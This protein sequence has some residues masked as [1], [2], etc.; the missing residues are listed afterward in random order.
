MCKQ[1]KENLL[2]TLMS[3][4]GSIID[5]LDKHSKSIKKLEQRINQLSAMNSDVK[6][7]EDVKFTIESASLQ[8]C[9]CYDAANGEYFKFL[10]SEHPGAYIVAI[11][12]E[13]CRKGKMLMCHAFLVHEQSGVE[14]LYVAD[15]TL[16]A[17]YS[18]NSRGFCNMIGKY[19][20]FHLRETYKEAKL[21]VGDVNQINDYIKK[22]GYT[23]EFNAEMLYP[24]FS[25]LVSAKLIRPLFKREKIVL[26]NKNK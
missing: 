22:V 17:P 24:P 20:S 7:R 25:H 21:T 3:N 16:S 8:T 26:A 18:N 1:L 9:S 13:P 12:K 19:A 15:E 2:Q 5:T 10:D 4:V 6:K 11:L 23:A 14:I